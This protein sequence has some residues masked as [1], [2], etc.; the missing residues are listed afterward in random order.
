MTSQTSAR[1]TAEHRHRAVVQRNPPHPEPTHHHTLSGGQ[2]VYC[3]SCRQMTLHF[4]SAGYDCPQYMNPAEYFI[5]LVNTDFDDHADVPQM[6][7]SYTQSEIR[8]ELINRI[9][10]DRKT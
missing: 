8:K 7:Q 10:S 2:T 6:V 9:K 4:A 5:S 3:G 1:S